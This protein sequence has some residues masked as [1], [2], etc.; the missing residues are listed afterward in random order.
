MGI[1]LDNGTV[2]AQNR[3]VHRGA[4]AIGIN[5]A[6]D[7][8]AMI[9]LA[10]GLRPGDEIIVPPMTFLQ[11]GEQLHPCRMR[12][13]FAD[14]DETT[15][16]LDPGSVRRAITRQTRAI[17]PVHLFHQPADLPALRAL[18]IIEHG[19]ILL[20]DSAESIGM[21][22][23]NQHTGLWGKAGVLSFFPTKTLGA[24]GD[25]MI[26]TDDAEV[27]NVSNCVTMAAGPAPP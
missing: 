6:S 3:H 13:V 1:D 23:G 20:E 27:R 22:C 18:G 17:M 11:H 25:G 24:F 15:Y 10:A 4:V 16:A 7:G 26:L 14:I 9:Q 21:W 5:N 8:L 2:R 19:L 12:P